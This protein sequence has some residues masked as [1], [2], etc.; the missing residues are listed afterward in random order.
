MHDAMQF[1][2]RT[3]RITPRH[4]E[5][6]GPFGNGSENKHTAALGMS[7]AI[8]STCHNAIPGVVPGKVPGVVP[9]ITNWFSDGL[10]L[11]FNISHQGTTGLSYHGNDSEKCHPRTFTR[12][13]CIQLTRYEVSKALLPFA[14]HSVCIIVS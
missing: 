9:E 3:Q 10:V 1:A 4:H 6:N 12:P 14:S 8:K 2:A 11:V 5:A 13:F 7:S